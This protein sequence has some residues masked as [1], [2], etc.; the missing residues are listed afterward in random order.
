MNSRERLA[1]AS[2]NKVAKRS[3]HFTQHACRALY[4]EKSKAFGQGF[5]LLSRER[6]FKCCKE[7]LFNLFSKRTLSNVGH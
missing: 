3:R 2:L 1:E 5:K 6:G 4:S 7:K